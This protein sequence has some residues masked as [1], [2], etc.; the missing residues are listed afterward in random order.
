MAAVF[1]IEKKQ[2]ILLLFRASMWG[3]ENKRWRQNLPGYQ[4]LRWCLDCLK[5]E[6]TLN[7]FTQGWVVCFHHNKIMLKDSLDKRKW[8]FSI[9][10]QT[11]PTRKY[12]FC[13]ALFEPSCS[14]NNLIY[15]WGYFDRM[16]NNQLLGTWRYLNRASW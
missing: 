2:F 9:M 10:Q 12:L 14:K 5:K 4:T 6:F 13:D 15:L 7:L 8:W 1:H 16:F 3:S 11:T